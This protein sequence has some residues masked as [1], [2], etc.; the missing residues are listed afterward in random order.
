MIKNFFKANHIITMIKQSYFEGW[1]FKQSNENATI[2]FIPA[3]CRDKN[4]VLSASLQIITNNN[5]YFLDF[6]GEDFSFK[7]PFNIQ[8]KENIFSEDGIVLDIKTEILSVKANLKFSAFTKL[9]SDIMGPFKYLP[10]MQC[11][12]GVIS[13]YH[14][15]NGYVELNG[16]K[17]EFNSG[18]G[19]IESDSGSSFPDVYLWS[20]CNY[21]DVE[22]CSV[23]V[24]VAKI[25]FLFGHFWGCICSVLYRGRQYRVATYCG[26]KIIEFKK[27]SAKLRQ[28]NLSFYVE[29][30]EENS[31]YLKAPVFGEMKR[32]LKE[33]P[34]CKVRYVLK[35]NENTVFD[36]VCDRAGFEYFNI[37][38]TY[39]M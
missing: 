30:L 36:F 2:A 17:F 32:L 1:Y 28:G 20:Q 4:G 27:N 22:P 37:A 14:K 31:H 29:R 12:H 21:N 38:A 19:Y 24:S 15:V 16:E 6:K 26:A 33:S 13:M 23:M 35:E 39:K 11:R 3:F 8:L 18:T 9:K 10:F 34:A 25:P 5:S 7:R